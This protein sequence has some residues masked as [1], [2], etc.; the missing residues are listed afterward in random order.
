[1]S[2]EGVAV[3]GAGGHAGVVIDTLLEAGF[4]VGG[5]F[6]DDMTRHGTEI[7]GYEV[8]GPP[9]ALRDYG[10]RKAI[11]AIGDNHTRYAMVQRF[12]DLEWQTVIHPDTHVHPNAQI[13]AG[14]I[15]MVRSVIRPN[16]LIGAHAII[17]T[18]AVVGHECVVED[19]VH[20]AGST[21]LGGECYIE[22]GVFLG[23]GV[24][25]VPGT[26]VGAWSIVGAGGAITKNVPSQV[27][28]VGVPAQV[29]K[30]LPRRPL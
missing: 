24:V 11:V 12:P 8:L 10:L 21:H 15:V 20:V 13:G 22:T 14:T 26:R 9:E 19:F 5:V 18:A 7:L 28:A 23:L 17:N 25:M 6:D 16:V 4:S 2:M 27:L 30:S 29:K 1:M 3:I